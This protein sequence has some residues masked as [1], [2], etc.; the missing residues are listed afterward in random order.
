MY[1]KIHVIYDKNETNAKVVA[2]QPHY[3]ELECKSG[4]YVARA[5]AVPLLIG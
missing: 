4:G 5:S 1:K 2:G 3:Y